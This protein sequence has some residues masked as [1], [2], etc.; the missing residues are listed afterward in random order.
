ML[1]LLSSSCDCSGVSI[2]ETANSITLSATDANPDIAGIGAILAACFTAILTAITSIVLLLIKAHSLFRTS[3]ERIQARAAQNKT[4][5][6]HIAEAVLLNLSDQ[7]LVIGPA[8]LITAALETNW[9]SLSAYH[10]NIVFYCAILAAVTH[11]GSIVTQSHY[12]EYKAVGTFR[13]LMILMT[14]GFTAAFANKRTSTYFPTNNSSLQAAPA[15]CLVSRNSTVWDQFTDEN[16][17]VVTN[18]GFFEMVALFVIYLIAIIVAGVHSRHIAHKGKHVTRQKVSWGFSVFVIIMTLTLLILTLTRL[19]K[20]RSWMINDSN[21]LTDGETEN[22]WGFGQLLP[23]LLFVVMTIYALMGAISDYWQEK[24]LYKEKGRNRPAAAIPRKM[25][26][27]Q[28]IPLYQSHYDGG[29]HGHQNQQGYHNPP[30]G[31]YNQ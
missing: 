1:G 16:K 25:D 28:E 17:T 27:E 23:M 14:V 11:F 26:T 31:Y 15:A 13:A 5:L 9:C 6:R 8:T 20:L 29:H 3:R 21:L 30:Q 4:E 24:P 19:W 12:F 10:M 2:N 7:Q 18:G 22:Q